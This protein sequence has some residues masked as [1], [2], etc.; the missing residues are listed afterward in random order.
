LQN[1]NEVFGDLN[2]VPLIIPPATPTPIFTPTPVATPLPQLADIRIEG[3]SISPNPIQPNSNFTVNVTVANRGSTAAG[4]FAV[5]ATFQ[6]GNVFSSATVGSLASGST[7]TVTLSG[8]LA[9]TGNYSTIIVADLNNQVQEGSGEGNN[10]D[11]SVNYKV[12]QPVANSGTTT[13]QDVGTVDLGSAVTINWDG[14][15]LNAG[16]GNFGQITGVSFD[17]VHYDLINSNLTTLSSR[18]PNVGEIYGILNA[19]G[20]RGVIR[21]DSISDNDITVTYRSYNAAS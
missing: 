21:V 10:D 1:L 15:N 11:F 12:D 7:T 2:T 4:S 3:A 9:N 13:V 8:T 5:A 16:S 19:S 17:N 18:T 6:P 20:A 14:V